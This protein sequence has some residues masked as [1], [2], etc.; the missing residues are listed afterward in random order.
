MIEP[1]AGKT[2]TLQMGP[3]HPSTHGVLRLVLEVD[4][5]R[6]LRARPE[7]G[8]L[9]RCAEKL[10]ERDQYIQAITHTDRLDYCAA[11]ANNLGYVEAVEALLGIEPPR[12]A[13]LLR[14]LLC[15]LQRIA[16]HLLFIGTHVL[17]L[18]AMSSFFYTFRERDRILDLFEMASGA[19]LTYSYIRFGGFPSPPPARFYA[20]TRAFLGLFP[21]R[22]GQIDDLITENPIFRDRSVG[23]GILRPQDAIALGASGPVLRGSG[24]KRDLRRDA[25]YAAYE[26]LEFEVVIETGCDNY[27]RYLVRMREIRESMRLCLACLDLLEAA[28]GPWVV[29][30]PRV[31]PPTREGAARDMAMMTRHWIIAIHG[32][33]VPAGEV[34]RATETPRGELGVYVVSD[35]SGRPY[36]VHYRA[37]SFAHLHLLDPLARGGLLADLVGVIGSLDVVLGEVDR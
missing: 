20:E 28:D 23:V 22:L 13:R 29:D 17:D 30:D 9:H 8:Y 12:R 16:S 2:M 37:P 5:E 15:E 26:E 18:G 32:F 25:P 34:Y 3:H 11:M 6:V 31:V 21:D 33:D 1:A 19:R 4:G 27:A 10:A 36:R 35:G 14:V 7:V 24:V